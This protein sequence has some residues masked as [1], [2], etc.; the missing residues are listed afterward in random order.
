MAKVSKPTATRLLIITLLSPPPD[1]QESASEI[2]VFS[3]V[4]RISDRLTPKLNDFQAELQIFAVICC[5]SA[6]PLE[7]SK[8]KIIKSLT[9]KFMRQ[10]FINQVLRSP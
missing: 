5:F 3:I 10:C 9:I 1:R 8:N 4:W 6:V 7:I 2:E